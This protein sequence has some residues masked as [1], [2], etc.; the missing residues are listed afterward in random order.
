MALIIGVYECFKQLDQT[1]NTALKAIVRK[2]EVSLVGL[3]KY[4]NDLRDIDDTVL[5]ELD[6]QIKYEGY[7]KRQE[8]DI[9]KTRKMDSMSLADDIDYAEIPG[10][11]NEI[12]EKLCLVKPRTLGQASRISG[13]TPAAVTTLMIFLR[14]LKKNE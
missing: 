3:K 4:F 8:I 2:P 11:S 13:V 7:I 12:V 14:A 1:G 10:L 9:M 5:E 6:I